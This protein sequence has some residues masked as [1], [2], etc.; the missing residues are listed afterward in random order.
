MARLDDAIAGYRQP[1]SAAYRVG[2]VSTV[3]ERIAADRMRPAF[4]FERSRVLH[5]WKLLS[6]EEFKTAVEEPGGYHTDE[7]SRGIR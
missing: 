6:S 2:L 3:Q 1:L 4:L 5:L 7:M